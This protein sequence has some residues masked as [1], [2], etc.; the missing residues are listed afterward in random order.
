MSVR[1]PVYLDHSASTPLDLRAFEAMRPYFM[2][3]F[4]NAA[5]KTHAYGHAA[6]RA[7]HHARNQVAALLNVEQDEKTGARE[8]I[9][10]SGATESNNL[11]IKGVADAYRDK[12]RHV[13]TQVTEHKSVIDTCQRLQRD[14]WDVT[15][16]PV[17]HG[18]RVSPDQVAGAIRPDTVLVSVMWANNETG[19]IQPAREIGRTCRERGVLF[20]TDATQA[21]GKVPIDVHA[22]FVDLLSFTGHKMYG[23]KGCGGLFVRRKDP[24][25]R[26]TAQMDG[27]GHERGFRSGTLNVPGI[28]GVG[29]ACDIARREMAGESARLARL[30][31]RL[32]SSVRDVLGGGVTVNGDPA[33]RLPHVS[34]LSFAGVDGETILKELSH[35]LAV[36]SGSACQSAS[37]QA[38]YVLLSMGVPAALA[39]SSIR[40]S[41]GRGTTDEQ[42]EYAVARVSN[43]ILHHRAIR[44]PVD[45]PSACGPR[46]LP[47]VAEPPQARSA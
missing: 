34:N 26:L 44:P 30:R 9:W 12:G 6:E 14:G 11:A 40:F 45:A 32:E 33:H 47:A 5:S 13:V 43:V 28:V 2:E 16:L 19:A 4:G 22:D 20:H 18:G 36:S 17:D 10:T 42:V 1:L 25:V 7:V 8:I 15:W 35:H 29:A 46:D 23:P 37:L 31:D 38:S 39:N 3:V 21:V 41:L 27:G 24:R